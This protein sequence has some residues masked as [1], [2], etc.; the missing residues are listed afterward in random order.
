MDTPL[1]VQRAAQVAAFIQSVARYLMIE[2]PFRPVDDDYLV[3]RHDDRTYLRI[4]RMGLD[5]YDTT[6]SLAALVDSTLRRQSKS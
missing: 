1:T 4:D 6:P 2:R 3:Y 5:P